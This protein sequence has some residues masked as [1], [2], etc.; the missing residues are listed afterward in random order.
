M[1]ILVTGGAGFIGSHLTEELLNQGHQVVVVDDLSSGSTSN[2]PL[3]SKLK[4][5]QK[6]ILSCSPG[7]IQIPIDAIAHLAAIPSV[8]SSWDEPV[9][10]HT[11][12]LSATV[13]VIELCKRM[14]VSKVVFA[15]SAA[16]YGDID[17]IPISEQAP[18][19]PISPYGLQKLASEDYLRLFAK[20]FNI[21]AVALR[22]FNVYGPRQRP[23]SAYSGVISI[24]SAAMRNNQS[25]SIYGDGLQTRDFVFVKDVA[26]A[27]ALA[28]TKPMDRGE[29]LVCNVAT[30]KKTSLLGLVEA[31][32]VNF[33]EWN[34]GI[35]FKPSRLGDILESQ[36]DISRAK[37]IGFHPEFDIMAGLERLVRFE[38]VKV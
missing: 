23:D 31:L 16:V 18:T 14:N 13:S 10:S 27:F 36:A 5:I 8:V 4:F 7:D 30:A 12:N 35:E 24:F 34:S 33:P 11:S 2:L 22:L 9:K 6:D 29:F 26:K 1:N 15:S 21:S 32:R 20:H 17:Q 37:E 25:I 38:D 19:R 28:L 3:D